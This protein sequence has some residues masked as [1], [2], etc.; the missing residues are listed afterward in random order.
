M[1]LH[2]NDRVRMPAKPEW[3]LGRVLQEP[4]AGKVSVHFREAGEK[5]LSL[6]HAQMESV[7]GDAARDAWLDNVDLDSKNGKVVFNRAVGL[8]DTWAKIEK[9]Q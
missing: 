3:G 7:E 8:K 1:E 5:V 6:K 4:A 2:R 9:K